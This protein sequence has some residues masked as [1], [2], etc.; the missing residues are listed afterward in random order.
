V[1]E[2]RRQS[3]G[4]VDTRRD[5]RS[6]RKPEA[7]LDFRFGIDVTVSAPKSVSVLQALA[8]PQTAATIEGCHDRAVQQALGFTAANQGRRQEDG[9]HNGHSTKSVCPV[10]LR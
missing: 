10:S 2:V 8:D 9:R 3:V 7:E 5:F 4:N 6:L 1:V